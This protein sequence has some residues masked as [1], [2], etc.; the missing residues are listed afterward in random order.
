MLKSAVL[1]EDTINLADIL[2]DNKKKFDNSNF[3]ITG[4]GGFLGK[5]L[6]S[7]I[8]HLNNNVLDKPA[9]L[10]CYD[11]FITGV[12]KDNVAGAVLGGVIGSAIVGGPFPSQQVNKGTFD[13]VN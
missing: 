8:Y 11:N 13:R 4:A 10:Y 5:Y 6:V 2:I 1:R 9:T 7:T 3:L 12:N